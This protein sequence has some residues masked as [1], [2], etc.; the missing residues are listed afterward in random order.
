[1]EAGDF[2]AEMADKGVRNL[3]RAALVE[4]S[5]CRLCPWECGVDRL[6]G[7][8]GRCGASVWGEV[9]YSGLLVNEEQ[10]LNP[11]YEVFFSGCNLSCRFCYLAD[12]V[13][14]MGHPGILGH[15]LFADAGLGLARSL[16]AVGGEPGVNL[17]G[18]LYLFDKA[19]LRPRVWNSNMFYS[20]LVCEA[21]EQVAD[22]VVADV[23]F[24][25]DR[26][27]KRIAGAGRYLETVL[28]N[29]AG[30]IKAGVEVI[31]RHLFLPGHLEC[32]GLPVVRILAERFPGLR[33]HLLSDYFPPCRSRAGCCP[34]LCGEPE[35]GQ[36][37]VVL[38]EAGRRG[39]RVEPARRDSVAVFAG[40]AEHVEIVIDTCGRVFIP[41][42]TPGLQAMAKEIFQDPGGVSR[43]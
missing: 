43:A 12:R 33:F 37:G 38:Q 2:I 13:G 5:N 19:G 32:C 35:A 10:E 4:Y 25:N 15:P 29:I 40:I 18:C 8:A 11:A 41:H 7:E 31:V 9:F 24:G 42:F 6:A 21:V 20:G 36:V 30:A 34:E 1:M 3:A 26:C 27:A 17:L 23:H 39:L 22:I 16:C 28:H 14:S